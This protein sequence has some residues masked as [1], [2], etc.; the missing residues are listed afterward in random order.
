[1]SGHEEAWNAMQRSTRA[2]LDIMRRLG[3]VGTSTAEWERQQR[4]YDLAHRQFWDAQ[5]RSFILTGRY[6]WPGGQA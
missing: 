2:Q 6:S 5:S 4:L 1:M 3:T